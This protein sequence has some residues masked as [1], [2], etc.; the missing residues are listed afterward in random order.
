[1]FDV[2]LIPPFGING[3]AAASS[4]AYSMSLALALFYYQR[5]SGNSFLNCLLPR[6]SDLDLYFDLL[7]RARARMSA[8]VLAGSGRRG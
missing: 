5:L 4:I 2:L 6:P 1:V 3:A 7:K 8:G